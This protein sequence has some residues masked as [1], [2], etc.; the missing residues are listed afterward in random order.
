M[1]PQLQGRLV[2]CRRESG[3]PKQR[4]ERHLPQPPDRANLQSLEDLVGDL[5]DAPQL[6]D[7]Q[8]IEK[9]LYFT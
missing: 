4:G 8:R 6:P 9:R 5:S 2:A 7:R 1:L 3:Y